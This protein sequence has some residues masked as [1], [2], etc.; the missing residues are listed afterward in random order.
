METIL[1]WNLPL[2]I[3]AILTLPQ[4]LD[5]CCD[6]TN[7]KLL[8]ANI[9]WFNLVGK[10]NAATKE[11]ATKTDCYDGLENLSSIN[12]QWSNLLTG[13]KTLQEQME[14]LTCTGDGG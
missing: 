11:L 6:N 8:V 3:K 4:E 14:L 1:W 9:T 2:T 12:V 10:I 13:V 7:Y 5:D